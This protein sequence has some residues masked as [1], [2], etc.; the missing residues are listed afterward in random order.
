MADKKYDEENV[1]ELI[2]QG[3][4]AKEIEKQ[5]KISRTILKNCIIKISYED[6]TFYKVPGLIGGAGKKTIGYTK[7]GLKISVTK[8][9]KSDFNVDDE[10]DLK[11]ED[12]KIV[13][14]KV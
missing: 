13:L 3:V 4:S 14:T 9:K 7:T 11:F 5:T 2:K 8:M 12:D 1:F 6:S 10:F